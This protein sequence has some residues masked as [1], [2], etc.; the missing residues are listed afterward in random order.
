MPSEG[1]TYY[2]ARQGRYV[3]RGGDINGYEA[4]SN[5]WVSYVDWVGVAQSTVDTVGLYPGLNVPC[6]LLSAGISATRGDYAG[7]GLSLLAVIPLEGEGM[8]SGTTRT[9]RRRTGGPTPA[10]CA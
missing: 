2:D 1:G 4:A 9:L 7:A 5:N 3:T 8:N 10:C 6:S